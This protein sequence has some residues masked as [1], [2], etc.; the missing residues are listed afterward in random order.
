MIQIPFNLGMARI[1]GSMPAERV[2][3]LVK[4]RLKEFGLKMEDFFFSFVILC[5][6]YL[7][8]GKDPYGSLEML[9]S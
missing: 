2:K 8:V 9:E 5:C 3:N 4:E 6:L 7:Y 1:E